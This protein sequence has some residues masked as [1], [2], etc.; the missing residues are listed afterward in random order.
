MAD[1]NNRFT[2]LQINVKN[3]AAAIEQ[4]QSEMQIE[5]RRAELANAERFNL[6]HEALDSLMNNKSNTAE[7]SHG[8][9]NSN[10]PFQ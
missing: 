3:N 7:S 1:D 2:E 9:L 5:F 10:R 8:A 4:I 6:L